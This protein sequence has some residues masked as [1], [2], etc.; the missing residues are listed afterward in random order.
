[1]N[2]SKPKRLEHSLV[3]LNLHSY[4]GSLKKTRYLDLLGAVLMWKVAA[5]S[6][7]VSA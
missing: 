2:S 7:E 5:G 4:R 1:M 6:S 3:L